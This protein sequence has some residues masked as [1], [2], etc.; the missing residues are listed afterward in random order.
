MLAGAGLAVPVSAPPGLAALEL[1]ASAVEKALAAL[2]GRLVFDLRCRIALPTEV[3]QS[4]CA[5]SRVEGREE[6]CQRKQLP[7][8][9]SRLLPA[10][11]AAM[12]FYDVVQEAD[13]RP[14]PSFQLF[15]QVH[16]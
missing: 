5:A 1:E 16:T 2:D 13:S 7:I 15:L 3:A 4:S 12:L 8:V 9:E 6:K 14:P 11:Q 10:S